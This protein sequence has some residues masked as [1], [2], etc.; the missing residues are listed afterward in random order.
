MG[1]IARGVTSEH[2]DGDGRAEEEERLALVSVLQEFTVAALELFDPRSSADAFLERL[3]ERLG[4][5]VTLLVRVESGCRPLLLGSS[6]LSRASRARPIDVDARH[7]LLEGDAMGALPYPELAGRELVCWRLPVVTPPVAVLLLFFVGEPRLPARYRG[8]LQRLA[9]ILGR[10]LDHRDLFARSIES[11]RRLDEKK[12]VIECLSEA[13]PEG[14]LF[15]DTA[16]EILFFNRRFASMWGLDADVARTSE[17]ALDAA[18]AQVTDP[19]AFRAQAA[20]IRAQPFVE[21]HDEI[22]LKDGRIIE[23]QS[24]PVRMANGGLYGLAL[25][26]RDIT[27]RKK[28]EAER[29]ALLSTERCA[30]AA[31]EEAIRSRDDFLSIASHELRTPLTSL[32]LATEQVVRGARRLPNLPPNAMHALENVRQQAQRLVRLVDALLDVARI[33][34][35]RLELELEETDLTEVV[36]EVLTRFEAER[37]RSRSGL[38]LHAEGPVIGMWDRSRLDQV[39]TNLISNAI[40]YGRGNPIEVTVRADENDARLEVR[41]RGIGV[42][43]EQSARLFRR[44]E[45]AVSSRQYG[46]LGLGLF[47][48]REIVERHGGTVNVESTAEVGSTFTVTLPRRPVRPSR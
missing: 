36:S 19:E 27:E 15:I 22:A 17:S 32:L 6:G 16:G 40:K 7:A 13:S 30:R 38:V 26:F 14:V 39:A 48:V 45:R 1:T 35:G 47:I 21:T 42:T 10:V 3:A 41:D 25:F 44:F 29:E 33:Q 2:R 46:G 34:S 24:R 12:T 43:P 18:A 8:M 23:R 28:A 31:A 4:C 37:L 11:E 9:D 20:R 5:F